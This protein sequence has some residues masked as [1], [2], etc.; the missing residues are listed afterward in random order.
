MHIRYLLTNFYST[1]K[2]L[3]FHDFYFNPSHNTCVHTIAEQKKREKERNYTN[4]RTDV[5]SEFRD[6]FEN[7][8]QKKKTKQFIFFFYSFQ[9]FFSPILFQTSSNNVHKYQGI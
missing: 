6:S 8:Q 5:S 9:S 7:D 1:N 4:K 2:A 3:L